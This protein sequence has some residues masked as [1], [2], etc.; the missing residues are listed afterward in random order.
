[1]IQCH[2]QEGGVF[3]SEPSSVGSGATLG[4]GAFVHY[5]V[6]V[7][8]GVVLGAHAFLMKGEQIPDGQQWA[9][10]PAR[11]VSEAPL[12]A[13]TPQPR[14]SAPASAPVAGPP[15]GRC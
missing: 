2:S 14:L 10:N 7:G 3:R 4:V 1:M 8:D 12:A 11:Q 13:R 15:P 5:G 9:G 6:A